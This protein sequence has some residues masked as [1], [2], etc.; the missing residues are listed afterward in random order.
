MALPLPLSHGRVVL[1][2]NLVTLTALVRTR[3]LKD[4]GD[5]SPSLVTH[6]CGTTLEII[7]Y[8]P[9]GFIR[10]FRAIIYRLRDPAALS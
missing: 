5:L 2:G 10:G 6:T 3:Q 7:A 1:S 4:S 9:P 8:T